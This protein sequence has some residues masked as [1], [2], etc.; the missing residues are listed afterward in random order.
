MS[1]PDESYSTSGIECPYCGREETDDIPYKDGTTLE[2]ECTY[3]DKHFEVYVSCT[4]SW[5]CEPID[6]ENEK[7][8]I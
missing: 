7:D 8:R 4:W 2:W 3:C 5:T 1:K 6:E